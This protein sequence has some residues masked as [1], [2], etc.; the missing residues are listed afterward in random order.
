M[1]A[2]AAALALLAAAAAGEPPREIPV[3]EQ[4]EVRR[5]PWPV[6]V[7]PL[8]GPGTVPAAAASA[9]MAAAAARCRALRPSDVEVTEDGT[10][11]R[12]VAIDQ[13]SVPVL[14]AVVVDTSGSMSDSLPAIGD[15]LA[16]FARSLAP[17]EQALFASLDD[18]FVLLAPPAGDHAELEA[19]AHRLRYGTNTLLRESLHDLLLYLESRPGRKV[20]FLVSDG[21]DSR[22]VKQVAWERVSNAA[23][24]IPDL[25]VFVVGVAARSS[26]QYTLGLREIATASGGLYHEV[27]DGDDVAEALESLRE[28][29]ASEATVV[30]EPPA[31]AARAGQ[32]PAGQAAAASAGAARAG[33][34]PSGQA[35]ATARARRV[36]VR[37]ADG[38]PCR[39]EPARSSRALYSAGARDVA[40]QAVRWEIGAGPAPECALALGP[41]RWLEFAAVE[42]VVDPGPL[43]DP[44]RWRGERR[45]VTRETLAPSTAA[46]PLG[47]YLAPPETLLRETPRRADEILWALTTGGGVDCL[48]RPNGGGFGPLVAHGRTFLDARPELARRTAES[49]PAWDRFARA[50]VPAAASLDDART[51]ALAAWLGD[52]PARE[53]LLAL[54]ARGADALL[55]G[56]AEAAARLE[57]AW[58]RLLDAFGTATSAGV[59]ALLVPA[60]APGRDAVG[61]WR[62]ALPRPQL[63]G[64]A[65]EPTPRAPLALAA[66]RWI[67]GQPAVR[68]AL[69]EG[70]TVESAT[71]APDGTG[72]TLVLKGPAG[73]RLALDARFATTTRFEPRC[74][75]V[76]AEPV[77]DA[78]AA[79]AA[80]A[81]DAALAR[82]GRVCRGPE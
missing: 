20:L 42:N 35:A 76:R 10:A 13:G 46:R 28:R 27:G 34:S 67:A 23:A 44:S 19:A 52:V 81:V 71:Q 79:E 65:P 75:A 48:V 58:P 53:L 45:L 69:P 62:V 14:Y 59:V 56:R 1:I 3:V 39:L 49:D 15:A 77:M 60:L 17:H 22:A 50:A 12:V 16:G 6:V 43:H 73:G 33:Q 26:W 21:G 31:G 9:A 40:R 47:L 30:Y 51:E 7:E 57:T 68:S 25:S 11:A 63:V 54:E 36:R 38:L 78:R 55:H 32:N 66:A 5:V 24:A 82:A 80:R 41:G 8:P 2:L 29:I 70:W 61:Y 37:A 72:A 18:D 4:V 64:P 74:V